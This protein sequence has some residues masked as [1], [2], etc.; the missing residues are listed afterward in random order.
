LTVAAC[1]GMLCFGYTTGIIAGALL[2]IDGSSGWVLSP[3][4]KGTL[5]SSVT[6][7][8]VAGTLVA[9]G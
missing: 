6:L 4:Q 3:L 5:V 7:G 8:A 1:L 9:G 2:Y